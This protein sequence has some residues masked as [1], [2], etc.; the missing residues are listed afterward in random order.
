MLG[1]FFYHAKFVVDLILFNFFEGGCILFHFETNLPIV[2]N[3]IRQH[4]VGINL[5]Q[6]V[7][8]PQLNTC[9]NDKKTPTWNTVRGVTGNRGQGTGQRH[10]YSINGACSVF[11][12]TERSYS[13]AIFQRNRLLSK[14]KTKCF[15]KLPSCV[16]D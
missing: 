4:V 12:V 13:T 10:R 14:N 9:I 5:A 1:I 16:F 3:Q 11:C 2:G 6:I 7:F 15:Q 8:Y